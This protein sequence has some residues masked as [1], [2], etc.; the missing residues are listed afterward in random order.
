M[1]RKTLIALTAA[2]LTATAGFAMGKKDIVDTAMEA[3]TFETLTLAKTRK[4][5]VQGLIAAGEH[6]QIQQ[7]VNPSK[8]AISEAAAS[9]EALYQQWLDGTYD[10]KPSSRNVYEQRCR[11]LA[12]H[13]RHRNPACFDWQDCRE[14]VTALVEQG[15]SPATVKAYIGTFKQVLDY[16]GVEP[17]PARDW[18]VKLPRQESKLPEVPCRAEIRAIRNHLPQHLLIPFDTLEATGIRIG[19]LN[20]LTWNDLDL[21]ES[22]VRI[23]QGK[24]AAARRWV[25]FLP[26]LIQQIEATRPPADTASSRKI[27]PTLGEGT[28]RHAIR[29]A[30]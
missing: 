6:D 29:K 25:Q 21:A 17:N 9:W 3:G 15:L 13:I 26:G 19:E 30:L 20:Q 1:M 7:L 18:R 5:K 24:T 16:A 12:R 28:L 2:T 14:L 10:V 11:A 8:P 27:F 23:A 4:T 22:R